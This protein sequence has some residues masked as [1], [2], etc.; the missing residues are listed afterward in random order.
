MKPIEIFLLSL[1]ELTMML[2]IFHKIIKTK[3]IKYIFDIIYIILG[4][5]I[6]AIVSNY[7]YNSTLSHLICTLS[8]Y[9]LFLIYSMQITDYNI[10]TRT[11]IYLL[12]I[13]FGSVVQLTG[14]FIYSLA[15]FE[16]AYAFM[17]G[18]ITQSIGLIIFIILTKFISLNTLEIYIKEKNVYFNFIIINTFIIIYSISIFWYQSFENLMQF[19]IEILVLVLFT[20]LIN[21]VFIRESLL[22]KQYIKKIEMYDT[23]IPIIKNLIDN[24]RQKQHDYNNQINTIVALNKKLSIE[25]SGK[26]SEYIE[27]ITKEEIWEDL[28]CLNNDILIALLYSK[29]MTAKKN[30]V[31]V[32]LNILDSF[33]RTTYS[34][35]E[36][37]EIYGI[38]IDNAME[39]AEKSKNN[40]EIIIEIDRIKNKHNLTIK[41]TAFNAKKIEIEK[42]TEKGYTT[43]N[44]TDHGIGLYKLKKLLEKNNGKIEINYDA[45]LEMIETKV[46]HY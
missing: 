3:N 6:V 25:L 16:I 5:A 26:K 14:V 22:N 41:N 24:I 7:I 17:E 19:Y 1:L 35:Y 28:L 12:M 23:Y 46:V 34:D 2:V 38:L 29:C 36:I 11:I 45:A 18:I 8:S 21:I 20:I 13:L 10:L 15:G 37:V 4:S 40:K 42:L 30:G 44:G 43:K 33:L 31:Q 27:E 9:L 39:A 32:K